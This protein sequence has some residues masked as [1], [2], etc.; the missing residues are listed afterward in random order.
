MDNRSIKKQEANLW[1]ST[2]L[3]RSRSNLTSNQYR[4][5]APGLIFL[6]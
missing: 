5:P 3:L 4:M 6:R 1:E 2:V